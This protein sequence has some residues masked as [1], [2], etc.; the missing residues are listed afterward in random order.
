MEPRNRAKRQRES[1]GLERSISTRAGRCAMVPVVMALR[2]YTPPIRRLQEEYSADMWRRWRQAKRGPRKPGPK[3]PD[4]SEPWVAEPKTVDDL[5][6]IACWVDECVEEFLL[7]RQ[8]SNN[9]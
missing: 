5:W 9:S 6:Q 4:N 3:I 2:R 1:R 7:W 8:P